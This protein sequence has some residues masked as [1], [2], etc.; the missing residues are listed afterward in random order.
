MHIETHTMA[1]AFCKK[2]EQYCRSTRRREVHSNLPPQ[3][4]AEKEFK[5]LG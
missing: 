3:W 1:P 5:G 4:P 2:K